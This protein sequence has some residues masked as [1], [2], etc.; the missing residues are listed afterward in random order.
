MAVAA[1]LILAVS[2][3]KENK[4]SQGQN[5]PGKIATT[6]STKAATE[7]GYFAATIN[8]TL[9]TDNADDINK[10]VSFLY[11]DEATTLEALK[12]SGTAISASLSGESFSATLSNLRL[13]KTYF[14]TAVAKVNDKDFY[15]SVMTFTTKTRSVPSGAIELELSVMWSTCNL[16]SDVEEGYGDYFSWGETEIKKDYSWD[17][18]KWCNGDENKLTKYITSTSYGTVDNKTEL[19]AEDDVAHVKLGGNWRIPTNAEWNELWEKC[20]WR[21][22]IKNGVEGMLVTSKKNGNSIFLPTAGDWL[23]TYCN[24]GTY[25]HYWSSSLTSYSSLAWHII[26]TRTNAPHM[27]GEVRYLGLSVRP[28]TE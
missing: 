5:K 3:S 22:R 24:S 18:Y 2:C 20:I 14:Y 8:G 11:S 16:G 21:G 13:H 4:D 9:K 19:E 7:I 6:V 1:A 17:T 28:V 27:Q 23:Y 26:F 12:A 10:E 15:G 25:G